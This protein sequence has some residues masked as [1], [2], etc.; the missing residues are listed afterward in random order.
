M[1]RL[2]D[3]LP[4]WRGTCVVCWV[5]CVLAAASSVSA[6]ERI[7]AFHSEIQIEADGG[8]L[9]TETIR[10]H[11]EGVNIRRGI[12]RE[13]PTSYRDRLGNVYNV[14]F[15]VLSLTRDG[16]AEPWD[17]YRRANGMRVDF[18][19]DSFLEVP[20]DYTYVLQ[21]RTTRQIGFFQDH[22]E[23]YWN[24]TGLGWDFMIEQASATVRLP[25]A[26]PAVSLKLEGYSGPLR[27]RG[28]DYSA[29][30]SDGGGMI[31]MTKPLPPHEGLTLVLRWP[32]GVV[33][34]PTQM[35]Q[36]RNI[37]HD[38]RG[39]LL[40]LFTLV[41]TAFYLAAA[42]TR[43]GR[44]PEPGVIF[45]HY[46]PPAGCSPALSN[47][48]AHMGY[49]GKALTAALVNLAVHGHLKIEQRGRK[50]LLQRQSSTQ[51]QTADEQV[52]Y[53]KLFAQGD[54]V[55]LVNDNHAMIGAA[56]NAH[57][58]AL[59]QAAHGRYYLDNGR[60]LLP[61]MVGSVLMLFVIFALDA[62]VPMVVLAFVV[63]VLMHIVFTALMRAPTTEG[64]ELLDQLAGFKLYLDV[65][66][67]D[68][69]NL[70][71]PP[72]VTPELF[73]RYLPYAIALG[74]EQHWGERFARTLEK[75]RESQRP[76]HYYPMW[77]TGPFNPSHINA[78][79]RSMGQG[80]STAISSAA[81]APGSS[82]G[83]GGGGFSGGGGGGGGGGGR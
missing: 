58:L 35:Q 6:Q 32:K 16:Q 53:R 62:V 43:V 51:E 55:M 54:T 3:L 60:Y 45:P 52:L 69:M 42:W 61:S 70:R 5:V 31:R 11:A 14:E 28:Q 76:V 19:D 50:Y 29:S 72:Q 12:Y 39:V 40:A 78:F 26:V 23:L 63:I 73:E 67:K 17:A 30:V 9:V 65:A 25:E 2:L 77:Y 75:L 24:V 4:R 22:D 20:A 49:R 74:V 64:R 68:E 41:A 8:M 47:F 10:V 7:L 56:R 80:F 83:A 13:F 46:H 15:N 48:V 71:N 18:G 44:D 82:S 27:A 37:I 57:A 36:A 59:K 34:Q 1:R 38:N 79:T 21:Y 33:S 81:R 66:E